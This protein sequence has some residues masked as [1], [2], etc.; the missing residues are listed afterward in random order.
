MDEVPAEAV[1]GGEHETA[2]RIAELQDSWR[3]TAAELD[4]FR[5][6]SAR[7]LI[8]ARE[9][10]R[11]SVASRWLPVVDNLERALD[12]A[13]SDSDLIAEGV[14]AVHQQALAVLADLGFPRRDDETGKPFNPVHHDAVGTVA[15]ADLVPGTVAHV[16]R[17][18]YGADGEILRPASVIVATRSE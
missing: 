16:V 8:R 18:G 9:Q 17:P 13:S 12:H 2:Q 15:D 3:R 14:R 4:N 11:A 6:R 10:E 7:E 1:A 5:K